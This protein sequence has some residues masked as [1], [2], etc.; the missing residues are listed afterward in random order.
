M[1]AIF[2][3][4]VLLGMLHQ[5]DA[6]MITIPPRATIPTPTIKGQNE[7]GIFA[8]NPTT[9][10]Q[11]GIN[12]VESDLG[13]PDTYIGSIYGTDTQYITLQETSTKVEL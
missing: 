6:S 10:G 11:I 9:K 1:F 5:A 3:F 4:C 13:D 12:P 2:P 8:V 7:G